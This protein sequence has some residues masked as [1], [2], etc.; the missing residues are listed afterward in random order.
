MNEFRLTGVIQN[1]PTLSEKGK[2]SVFYLRTLRPSRGRRALL[3]VKMI[4]F[5]KTAVRC[6]D[7]IQQGMRI[8]VFGQI[9]TSTYADKRYIRDGLTRQQATRWVIQLVVRDFYFVSTQFDTDRLQIA[10]DL[11]SSEDWFT[12]DS[13]K[14]GEDGDI[15]I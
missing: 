10:M 7:L 15:G 1:R 3:V 14:E 4:A 8:Q 12:I 13:R 5:G 2:V 11:A 9:T 6:H